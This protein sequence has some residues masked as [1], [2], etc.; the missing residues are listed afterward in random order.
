MGWKRIRLNLVSGTFKS[1]PRG[2][3]AIAVPARPIEAMP[4]Q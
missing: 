2:G 4:Q 1:P 3:I